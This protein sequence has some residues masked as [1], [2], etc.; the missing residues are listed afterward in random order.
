MTGKAPIA[1]NAVSDA[2]SKFGLL[3]DVTSKLCKNLEHVVL[4]PRLQRQSDGVVRRLTIDRHV[5]MVS[6]ASVETS[7]QKLFDDISK[8]IMFLHG[9]LPP[10]VLHRAKEILMPNLIN[11]VQSI[12]LSSAVP[13]DPEATEGL[14]TTVQS[15]IHFGN[16]LEKQRWPGKA[17]LVHWIEDIPCFWLD[18]RRQLSLDR[19]RSLLSSGPK[20]AKIVERVETQLVSSKEGIFASANT[21]DDWNAEWSD[22][23]GSIT[24][25]LAKKDV[26]ASSNDAAGDEEVAAWGLGEVNGGEA[27]IHKT[28]TL[29]EQA[30]DAWGWGEDE[31]TQDSHHAL[32]TTLSDH[33]QQDSNGHREAAT[34]TER[35]VT[36]KETYTITALPGDILETVTRAIRDAE[37]MKSKCAMTDRLVR[38]WLILTS[39]IPNPPLRLLQQDSLI[40][41]DSCSP[42]TELAHRLL[43]F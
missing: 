11:R 41:P 30:E 42:C 35:E 13:I 38:P 43:T 31:E 32:M 16:F 21:G 23:D 36:L 34:R 8:V 19:V 5:L 4:L 24:S 9:H 37:S 22:D 1:L 39:G 40:S 6:E 14:Q 10:L 20:G 33:T 29:N 28:A 12:W 7:T 18:K 3:E 27:E 15:V 26:N 25:S 17:D 2:M